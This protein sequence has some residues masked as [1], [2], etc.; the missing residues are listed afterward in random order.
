M[1]VNIIPHAN[2]G[3]QFILRT[4]RYSLRLFFTLLSIWLLSAGLAKATSTQ[5]SK[6]IAGPSPLF[7]VIYCPH[8]FRYNLHG[9]K[10]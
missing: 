5:T 1:A 6:P 8:R 10:M 4:S 3:L 7:T 2:R 9:I